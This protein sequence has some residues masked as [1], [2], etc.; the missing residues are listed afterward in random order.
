[1][2]FFSPKI[3]H[4]MRI[5]E[6]IIRHVNYINNASR[7]AS[8]SVNMLDVCRERNEHLNLGINNLAYLF[9]QK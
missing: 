5:E 2:L 1:M 4:M 3:I 8:I 7:R 6:W 9:V